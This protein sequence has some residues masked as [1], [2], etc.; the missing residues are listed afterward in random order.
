MKNLLIILLGSLPLLAVADIDSYEDVKSVYINVNTGVATGYSFNKNNRE[1]N[2]AATNNYSL[3]ANVGYN[4]NQFF[5]SELGY[6][7][8]W[9]GGTDNNPNGQVGVEDV[10]VKGTI[11]VGDV[12]ALYGRIGVGGYQDVSG[13]GNTNFA[14]NMGVLYGAGAQWSLSK[15]W[16]LRLEDWSVTGL[17][18]NIIQA[19][20]QFTF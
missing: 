2:G 13:N 11:P 4:Y 14:N 18:Q 20:T 16:A 5:A 6:N 15:H 17:G 8:L 3:G 9:L 1:N 7:H 19:G 10:A 12:F